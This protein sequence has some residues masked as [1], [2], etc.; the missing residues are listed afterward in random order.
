MV[1]CILRDGNKRGDLVER[2]R[3]GACRSCR[4]LYLR[5]YTM[6]KPNE[7]CDLDPGDLAQVD[8]LVVRPVAGVIWKHF[9]ARDDVSRWDVL[10]AQT[11]ATAAT[12]TQFLD[13]LQ[14][15]MAFPI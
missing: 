15:Q 7:Y 4:S 1:G 13:S 3:C 2:L 8:A 6:R 5:P 11:R 12:A 14:Q 10:Q 9:T